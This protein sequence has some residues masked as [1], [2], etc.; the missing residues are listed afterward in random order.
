MHSDIICTQNLIGYIDL[1]VAL[2]ESD[3][4]LIKSWIPIPPI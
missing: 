4:I 3:P 2:N 1:F